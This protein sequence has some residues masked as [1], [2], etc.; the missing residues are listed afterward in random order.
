MPKWN[1]KVRIKHLLTESEEHESVQRSMSAIADVL[2]KSGLFSDL[3]LDRWRKI[4][5]GDEY[6]GPVDY[7]NRLIGGM[8]DLADEKRIW[9]E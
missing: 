1:D 3:P 9:I 8:Y 6:F 2:E 5:E 4:P 7:A